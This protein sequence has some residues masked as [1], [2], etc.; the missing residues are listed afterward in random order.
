MKARKLVAAAVMLMASIGHAFAW[1]ADGHQV[2]GSIADQLLSARARSE[3]NR[4]LGFE[5]RVAAPW[6]DCVRSVVK[7][8]D[9][10]F[11]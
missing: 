6:A 1:G 2:V 7:N 4:I 8:A 9:G 3:V 5:L 11:K 10:T